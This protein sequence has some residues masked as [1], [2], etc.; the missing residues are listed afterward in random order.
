MRQA[1]GAI[2]KDIKLI[3]RY[4]GKQIPEGKVSLTYRLEYQSLQ[5]TLEEKDISEVHS[6][7]LRILENKFGA[8][9]R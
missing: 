6:N 9:L 3:D 5:K 7:I 1:A 8:R 2:L 4:M